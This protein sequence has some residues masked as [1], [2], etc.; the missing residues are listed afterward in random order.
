M[1]IQTYCRGL[2]TWSLRPLSPWQLN[3]SKTARKTFPSAL[4]L[5]QC[6]Q[7]SEEK[8]LQSQGYWWEWGK[9]QYVK[10]ACLGNSSPGSNLQNTCANLKNNVQKLWKRFWT[11]TEGAFPIWLSQN[12]WAGD[13]WLFSTHSFSKQWRVAF[14]I[15]GEEKGKGS[16]LTKALSDFH[17]ECQGHAVV[18]ISLLI[19][20]YSL[21]IATYKYVCFLLFLK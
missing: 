8:I 15:A 21:W 12:L 1:T 6:F 20:R 14:I 16:W 7:M 4:E 2:L 18:N 11:Y 5:F 3:F 9:R 17:L 10:K 13:I 19:S